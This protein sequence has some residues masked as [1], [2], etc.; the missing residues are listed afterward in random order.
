MA[1]RE[2]IGARYVPIFSDPL[3]WDPTSV[4]EP[5]TV[6]TDEGASYVSR[7]Y[8]PEGIQLDNTD[9][10]VL[11]ADFNAQLQHYIDEVQ[12]FDGRIDALEDALPIADFSSISTVDDRLDTIEGKFPIVS[13]DIT[14]GT[15]ATADIADS[16]VTTAK[17]ADSNV[18]SA[19]IAGS[20][21]TTAKIAD[22]AVTR[23]KME[24]GVFSRGYLGIVG[25]SFSDETS[26]WPTIVKNKMGYTGLI[27]KA[28]AGAGFIRTGYTNFVTQFN[29]LIAD[30]NFDKVTDIVI[31]G[32]VN[33]YVH[34]STNIADYVSAWTNIMTAYQALPAKTRPR[35]IMVFGNTHAMP[36]KNALSGYAA[37]CDEANI[38]LQQLGFTTVDNSK[39]WLLGEIESVDS[40]DTIH[41]NT[42]GKQIIAGYMLQV[43]DGTYSGVVKRHKI[44]NLSN[45]ASGGSGFIDIEFNNGIVSFYAAISSTTIENVTNRYTSLYSNANLYLEIGPVASYQYADNLLV[46]NNPR[47]WAVYEGTSAIYLAFAS[48]AYNFTSHVFSI[49][50]GGTGTETNVIQT[51]A[52]KGFLDTS[53]HKLTINNAFFRGAGN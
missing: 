14:D 36:E 46:A 31:Y 24:D 18:T 39:Y 15:I 13:A 37:F 17:I 33:D 2:Y 20:A 52:Q 12:T 3:Q 49:Y 28:V 19:K 51:L 16:A 5:L 22:S 32:G 30:A 7:Q 41:P 11:W 4:Y 9:Y 23:A 25:D 10:W 44:T 26:E 47:I 21:V 38:K 48:M 42:K 35:L 50:L 29:N 34:T 45:L 40:G 53:T 6:V 43:L 8:V 27:N 1:V